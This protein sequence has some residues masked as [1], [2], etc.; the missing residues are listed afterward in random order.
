VKLK[1]SVLNNQKLIDA[2]QYLGGQVLGGLTCYKI[3]QIHKG[4]KNK[5]REIGPAYR[6]IVK[7]YVK[8]AT[9]MK[10][11]MVEVDDARREELEAET[12]AFF[13]QEFDLDVKKI[14]LKEL[15]RINLTPD[16][17]EALEPFVTEVSLVESVESPSLK[18]PG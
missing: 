14:S 9:T 3:N 10:D 16:F 15:E 7:K 8:D 13:E 12:R 6:E 17:M 18:F 4:I 11:K 5:S 1:Y 2:L